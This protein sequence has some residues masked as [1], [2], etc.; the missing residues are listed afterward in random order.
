MVIANLNVQFFF[1]AP[2]YR[3]LLAS[4]ASS[5]QLVVSSKYSFAGGV[6]STSQMISCELSLGSP[7]F[8][9]PPLR[10]APALRGRQYRENGW[11]IAPFI[12]DWKL[13]KWLLA[14]PMRS[15]S[16]SS[17]SRSSPKRIASLITGGGDRTRRRL[18]HRIRFDEFGL[19]SFRYVAMIT[20]SAIIVTLFLG[21]WHF[22]HPRELRLGLGAQHLYLLLKI[23]A[24]LFVLSGSAGRFRAFVTIRS[25]AAR[26]GVS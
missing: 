25:S 18:S 13:R 24:L 26:L 16:W 9:F 12:G 8:R 10:P 1:D 3:F 11:L 7:S 15:R 17:R 6:R 19:F 2:S 4:M 23:A 22:Q 5:R 20:G 14:I 21:G